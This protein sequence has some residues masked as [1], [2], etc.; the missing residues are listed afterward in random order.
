MDF[1]SE[2]KVYRLFPPAHPP[3]IYLQ[4]KGSDPFIAPVYI[5]VISSASSVFP[6]PEYLR[7]VIFK[8]S[9]S[10]ST[11][12]GHSLTITQSALFARQ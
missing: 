3:S 8:D 10:A 9:G 6:K 1:T 7:T 5:F 12:S 4:T 2:Q 11:F